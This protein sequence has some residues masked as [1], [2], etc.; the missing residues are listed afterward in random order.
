M[1]R[2]RK[3]E[4]I[5]DLGEPQ[6]VT[7]SEAPKA[8]TSSFL[9]A[10]MEENQKKF[11]RSKVF[12][13]SDADKMA[14]GLPWP[15]FSLAYL[16]DTNVMPLGKIIGIAGQSQSQKSTLGF[17]FAKWFCGYGGEAKLVE[18]EGRKYSSSLIKSVMGDD[19]AD[20]RL[21]I[22]CA[23]T[24]EEAQ[25]HIST[26][27]DLY[28]Q[29]SKSKAG[30]EEA[31]KALV[32]VILD[33]LVGQDTEAA[34]EKLEK[35]GAVGATMCTIAKAWTGYLRYTSG[36]ISTYPMS[37][38]VINHLK[39]KINAQFGGGKVTPGGDS[40]RFYASLYLWVTRIGK[41]EK[42]TCF[43]AGERV[44]RH[45]DSRKLLLKV[46]KS[47]LGVEGRS[48]TVDFSWYYDENNKQVSYFAWHAATCALL[49]EMQPLIDV[50]DPKRKLRDIVDVEEV[51]SAN[52]KLYSSSTLGLSKASDTEI[53]AAIMKNPEL[54]NELL[55][56]HHIKMYQTWNG[57]MPQL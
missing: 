34:Y 28:N 54:Y 55:K 24:I 18:T 47:S 33:S 49:V 32:A 45:V 15:A 13:G 36:Q 35:T 4:G 52:M 41:D 21:Q 3:A 29:T 40:Q 38:I 25:Q 16:T 51:R 14:V 12:M 19:Y 57:S 1:A 42:E 43:I 53:G 23:D 50:R 30:A 17:E 56:F 11:G 20:N 5:G 7:E 26:V 9:S 2:G 44:E 48:I 46:D 31:R 6:E 39:E 8:K 10:S 37:L 22:A 27:I